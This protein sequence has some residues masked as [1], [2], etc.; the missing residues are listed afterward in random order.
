MNKHH[1]MEQL[2]PLIWQ[3]R[4]KKFKFFFFFFHLPIMANQAVFGNNVDARWELSSYFS[5]S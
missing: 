1:I 4:Q 3:V 5:Q 2:P